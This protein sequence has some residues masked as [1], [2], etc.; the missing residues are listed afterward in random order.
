MRGSQGCS[1]S[2][3]QGIVDPVAKFVVAPVA[4]VVVSPVANFVV[5]PVAKFVVAF[6]AKV[7]VSP[8]AKFVVAFV[9]KVLVAP[10][11]GQVCRRPC[12]QVC[13]CPCSQETF[14]YLLCCGLF[15]LFALFGRLEGKIL[16]TQTQAEVSGGRY[17]SIK[18]ISVESSWF[19]HKTL[20]M[21]QKQD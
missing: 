6:V 11:Y 3:S 12:S 10:V 9:A 13:G 21:I 20:G 18:N 19:R 8:V 16:M 2:C 14:N 7:V 1:W 5:N 4:K 15:L 17:D